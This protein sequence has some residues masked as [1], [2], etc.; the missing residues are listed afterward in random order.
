MYL[1]SVV[2]IHVS[3]HVLEREITGHKEQDCSVTNYIATGTHILTRSQEC[4][5]S[6]LLKPPKS[7]NAQPL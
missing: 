4:V 5:M 1:L 7:T 2:G 3:L 6:L